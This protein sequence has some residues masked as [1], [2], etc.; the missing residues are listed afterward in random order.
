MIEF[1]L[2]TQIGTLK[3]KFQAKGSESM[4]KLNAQA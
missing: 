1:K 4:P 3:F 2:I